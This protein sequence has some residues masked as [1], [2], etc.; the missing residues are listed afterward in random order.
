[1]HPEHHPVISSPSHLRCHTPDCD[2]CNIYGRTQDEYDLLL[3]NV[4]IVTLL[5]PVFDDVMLGIEE[6]L[7]L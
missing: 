6:N 7:R 3:F 5:E 1:M 2:T 4:I